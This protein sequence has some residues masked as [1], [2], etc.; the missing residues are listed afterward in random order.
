VLFRRL[1]ILKQVRSY[2]RQDSHSFLLHTFSRKCFL[3]KK[4]PVYPNISKRYGHGIGI[5]FSPVHF[6]RQKPQQVSCYAFF[7]GWLLLGLPPCCLWF[8][9]KFKT[10]NKNFGTLTTVSV[11]PVSEQHLT[12]CP[13]FLFI[14]TYE[15]W[16]GK[17]PVAIRLC[18][19]Y[20]Y[21][22]S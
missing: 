7:K 14:A 10:L 4:T 12:R 6:L 9:T 2:S 19:F 20:P 11:I 13:W 5:L 3:A 21:F 18:S 8:L 1:L 15:F 22:T 16:V 17:K